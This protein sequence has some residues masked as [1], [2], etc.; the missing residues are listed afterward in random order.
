MR[1]YWDIALLLLLLLFVGIAVAGVKGVAPGTAT[2]LNP[3][4]IISAG[5]ATPS[6]CALTAPNNTAPIGQFTSGTTG[7]C[8][9]TLTVPAS[10]NGNMCWATDTATAALGGQSGAGTTT[11]C[12]ISVT[13]TSGDVVRYAVMGF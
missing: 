9:V 8:T 6:G 4:Q 3:T 13:T 2:V 1:K 11:T 12:T 10:K 5:T 7:A